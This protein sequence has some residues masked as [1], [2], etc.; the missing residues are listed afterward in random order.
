MS[1]SRIP[2]A[3]ALTFG[4]VSALIQSDVRADTQADAQLQRIEALER[5]LEQSLQ[6][7]RALTERVNELERERA[8][9]PLQAAVSANAAMPPVAAAATSAAAPASAASPSAGASTAEQAE[10]I[11]NL[12]E[13]VDQIYQGL[14]RQ[15]HDTGIPLHGFADAKAAWST[16]EDPQRLRGFGGGTLDIYLTPQFDRVKSLFE[17]TVEYEPD[18]EGVID[19]ERMQ[20]GYALN[21]ALTVWAGRFHT[22]FGLWNT[23]FHHGANLQTSISR[24]RFIEFEDTGGLIAAHTVGVWASGKAPLGSGRLEYD[25]YVGNGASIRHRELDFNPF[26][27]DTNNKLVGINVGVQPAGYTGWTVGVHAFGSTVNTL[28]ESGAL[29]GSTKLRAFGGYFGYEDS[30]WEAIGEYYRFNNRDVASGMPNRSSAWFAQ[31]GRTFGLLTPF[32]RIERASLDPDDLYFRSL[33]DGASY[34]RLA[35]GARYAVD[36]RASFKIELSTTREDAA[37]LVDGNGLSVPRPR[38]AYRRASFQYS[39]AF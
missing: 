30:D 29:L 34:R 13:S 26:T 12:Q 4:L 20:L 18:G 17:L 22:P 27:D 32:A 9:P 11:A 2:R 39:I 1:N 15:S 35:I 33:L 6:T 37:T 5:R 23:W 16:H 3:V 24:P 25:A 7:V 21:N 14:S 36:P 28:D 8:A 31:A 38:S 19:M 10:A